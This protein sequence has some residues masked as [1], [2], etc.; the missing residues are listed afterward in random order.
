MNIVSHLIE[1]DHDSAPSPAE[2]SSEKGRV[3]SR[4]L[5][6]FPEETPQALAMIPAHQKSKR[7]E[8]AQRRI[9]RPFSVD[10]VEALVQAVEKFGTGR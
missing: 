9:R 8:L 6:A 4:A 10:E 7:A 5:V 1:S 3:D 2:I